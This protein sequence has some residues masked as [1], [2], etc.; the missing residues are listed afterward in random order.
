M[1]IKKFNGFI[2]N[3]LIKSKPKKLFQ[4]KTLFVRFYI[5]NPKSNV[6][7]SSNLQLKNQGDSKKNDWY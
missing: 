4:C 5:M 7:I 1:R 3:F 6:L 2:Y